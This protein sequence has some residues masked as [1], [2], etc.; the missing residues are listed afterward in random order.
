MTKIDTPLSRFN[1]K[2]V[3]LEHD[4]RIA[5][6]RYKA[7]QVETEE[8]LARYKVAVMDGQRIITLDG[9]VVTPGHITQMTKIELENK[10]I[11]EG[12]Y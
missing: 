7:L 4:T 3:E 12:D 8:H 5:G 1:E 2:T 6:E 9:K 10:R 11:K